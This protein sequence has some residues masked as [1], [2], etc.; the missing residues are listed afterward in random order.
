MF[1]AAET[2]NKVNIISFLLFFVIL[3]FVP[4]INVS[5]LFKVISYILSILIMLNMFIEMKCLKYFLIKCN[6]FLSV[7]NSIND[8]RYAYKFNFIDNKS[9]KLSY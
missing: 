2:S 4:V 1:F 5:S 9:C 7:K 8:L 3:Y 6:I